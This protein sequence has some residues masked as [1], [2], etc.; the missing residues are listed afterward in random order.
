[1]GAVQAHRGDN[2]CDP[3]LAPVVARFNAEKVFDLDDPLTYSLWIEY[4]SE[5]P[6][7]RRAWQA[8]EQ[9]HGTQS[10]LGWNVGV[11]A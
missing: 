6:E 8:F 11:T 2:A 10:V 5:Y 1:M 7:R 3:Q 9:E 4:L